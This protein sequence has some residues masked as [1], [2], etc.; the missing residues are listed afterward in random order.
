MD[1]FESQMWHLD[2]SLLML[3]ATR[4]KIAASILQILASINFHCVSITTIIIGLF[5]F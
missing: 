3:A 2:S 5:D 4:K 1:P